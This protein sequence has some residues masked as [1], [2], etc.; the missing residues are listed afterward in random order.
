MGSTQE[1]NTRRLLENEPL[2]DRKPS[3]FLRHLRGLA[4]AAFPEEVLQTLWLG[5]LPKQVQVL[6]A[7]HKDLSLDKRAEIA[8][9][10]ADVY[11]PHAEVSEAT[12]GVASINARLDYMQNALT[13]ALQELAAI[14][15]RCP[16]DPPRLYTRFRTRSRSRSRDRGQ[17]NNGMCWYHW[18]FGP[19]ANKCRKPCNYSTEAAGN[20][21]G[22]R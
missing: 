5:R 7:G 20:E 21:R 1:Q 12:T 19:E 22:S 3:Q 13:T 10:V 4:G 6:L 15:I 11:G 2:G 8:D 16:D 9:S 17:E 18:K 14:K